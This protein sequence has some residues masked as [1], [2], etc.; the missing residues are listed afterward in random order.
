VSKL[1][2]AAG[3][4]VVGILVVAG[5]G[6]AFGQSCQPAWDATIGQPGLTGVPY[7][8]AVFDD[9][10]GPALYV[11]GFFERAGGPTGI[12]VNNIA[13]WNGTQWSA[14]AQGVDSAVYAL[15]VYDDGTGSALYVGGSFQSASGIGARN[16]AK[17]NGTTWSPVG[18]GMTDGLNVTALTVFD[19]SNGLALYAAGRFTTA[20]GVPANRIARW[21]G[22]AWSALG[23]GLNNNATALT[24]TNV[25][26]AVGPA[27]YVGGNFTSA[28]GLNAY[29]IACWEGELGWSVLGNGLNN[30]ALALEIFNDGTG[31]ALYAGGKF[32][33]AGTV[34]AN[35][36]AKWNGT[37]W[38]TLGS[39]ANNGMNE[40]V[41][42]LAV[43]DDGTGGGAKLYAA[44]EF[45]TAGGA[46]IAC[47]ARWNHQTQTW[48]AL[49]D[50]SNDEVQTLA[51]AP[52]GTPIGP[53]LYVGGF[54][55]LVGDELASRIAEW[56]GCIDVQPGD[57]D[58]DGDIDRNDYIRFQQCLT[59]PGAG[60]VPPTCDCVK[61]DGDTDVDLKDFAAFQIGFTG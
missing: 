43:F 19:D 35:Y 31:P 48:S 23:S 16:I 32:T 40:R 50:G 18:G 36:I 53:S 42:A 3:R 4:W 9:G 33:L 15:A 12:V 39:G 29:R 13:K 49:G 5:G 34:S 8:L 51:V 26:S 54:F 20:G 46:P 37:T 41:N 60:P 56:V 1:T 24:A 2:R 25:A 52:A 10:T 61:F 11:G 45:T 14:L 21:N 30:N 57:C 22:T 7:A 28:G 27:L 38:S 17:W 58:E 55:T 44:G 6:D 47:I 59:G